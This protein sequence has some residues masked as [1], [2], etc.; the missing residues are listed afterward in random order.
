MSSIED[1]NW[2]GGATVLVTGGTGTFGKAFVKRVMNIYP[3]PEKIIVY[4]RDEF[5][6]FKMREDIGLP[7][8]EGNARFLLGDVRD[9]SRL[10]RAM[11]GVDY[12]IHAAALKQIPLCE[13]NP[14][15]AVKTNIIGTMNVL[16]TA[17]Y[18][19]VEKV[20][21]LSSDKAVNPINMYGSTKLAAEKLCI[22]ANSYLYKVGKGFGTKFSLVRYGNVVGSRGSVIESFRQQVETDGC[23]RIT[24]KLM[25]RFWWSVDEAVNFILA[26]L[27]EMIGGELFIPK[28]RSCSLEDILSMYEGYKAKEIGIRP[29]EKWHEWLISPDEAPRTYDL[30]WCYVIYPDGDYFVTRHKHEGAKSLLDF[31]DYCSFNADLRLGQ[32]DIERYF[33]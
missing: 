23:L 31:V 30:D 27:T 16:E 19:G 28:L 33:G 11:D 26:I 8:N 25:T 14:D 15:E 29:G 5:K 6:Q 4:S 7:Y 22:A 32:K 17:A 21:V 2:L 3:R 10:A 20:V 24:S 9:K 12:V 13:Y 18:A 1:Y